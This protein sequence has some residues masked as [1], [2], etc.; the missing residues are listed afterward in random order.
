DDSWRN[1]VNAADVAGL[2]PFDSRL[3]DG[4]PLYVE[5]DFDRVIREPWNAATAF[6]FV[7]IVL[8]WFWRVRGAFSRHVFLL[9]CMPILLAGGIGG[10]IYHALRRY[11]FAFWLD[12]IPIG[13][14]VVL[15]SAYLLIRLRPKWWHVVILAL[16]VS[17]FPLL[18][19]FHVETHV[20]IVV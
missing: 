11:R 4:G 15:G 16:L 3:P 20:A 13:L 10:T 18:F 8:V 9:A 6:L 17:L 12:V 1:R 5:T 19:V 14:L 7:I 2:D